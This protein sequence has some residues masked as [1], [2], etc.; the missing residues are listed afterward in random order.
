MGFQGYL[1]TSGVIQTA[2]LT[3]SC[4][5]IQMEDRETRCCTILLSASAMSCVL[6]AGGQYSSKV[7]GI[8]EEGLS[9]EAWGE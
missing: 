6:S 3:P 2:L 8:L 9:F 7:S 1:G 5:H 4:A